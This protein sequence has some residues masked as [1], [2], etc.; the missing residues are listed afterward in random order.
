ME[1]EIDKIEEAKTEMENH[2][3]RSVY[4]AVSRFN[5]TTGLSPSSINI[6]MIESTAIGSR[7]RSFVVGNV[8]S[9]VR[10]WLRAQDAQ[11]D[12]LE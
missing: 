7:R 9:D 2:I 10:L 11:D 12:A 8:E 6:S 5:E 4:E 1:T 3:Q